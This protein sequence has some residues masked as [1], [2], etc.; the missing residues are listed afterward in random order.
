MS[1]I[2][3]ILSITIDITFLNYERHKNF[4]IFYSH[5]FAKPVPIGILVPDVPFQSPPILG[6]AYRIWIGVVLIM[7]RIVTGG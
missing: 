2:V 3:L 4:I 6:G 7:N 1:A 5:V